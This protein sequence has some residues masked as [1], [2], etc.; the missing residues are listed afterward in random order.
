MVH[1]PP[2]TMLLG[3]AMNLVTLSIV[4]YVRW[5]ITLMMR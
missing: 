3:H 5:L 1:D 4:P 2:R